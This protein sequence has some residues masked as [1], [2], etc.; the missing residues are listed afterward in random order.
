M[1]RPEAEETVRP[2]P[3]G[4]TSLEANAKTYLED[5]DISEWDNNREDEAELMENYEKNSPSKLNAVRALL[6]NIERS[7]SA[8]IDADE[9]IADSN[10]VAPR[11]VELEIVRLVRNK[12]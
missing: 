5:D 11:Y 10:E 9:E 8:D 1:R 12:P 3:D 2:D 4:K 7:D 6:R